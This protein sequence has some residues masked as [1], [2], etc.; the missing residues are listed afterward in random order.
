[1]MDP[2]SLAGIFMLWQS[3]T[4]QTDSLKSPDFVLPEIK[5][6][7]TGE[8]IG[9]EETMPRPSGTRPAA[10]SQ[11]AK[12]QTILEDPEHAR[13]ANSGQ[14]V[15]Q[16]RGRVVC[17]LGNYRMVQ[18]AFAG[19]GDA[20][21]LQSLYAL[22]VFYRLGP[23]D[24]NMLN[25]YERLDVKTGGIW[26]YRP[27]RHQQV[28]I[29]LG[30]S[31]HA[32][33]QAGASSND[34]LDSGGVYID[35]RSLRT[36]RNETME[37]HGRMSA[38][39]LGP[40]GG[41]GEI[42]VASPQFSIKYTPAEQDD[43]IP[44]SVLASVLSQRFSGI[45]PAVFTQIGVSSKLSSQEDSAS[46]KWMLGI[47]SG[48][49]QG[50]RMVMRLNADSAGGSMVRNRL[51]AERVFVP[52][53]FEKI[54]G[55]NPYCIVN[56][57]GLKAQTETR[58]RIS[59]HRRLDKDTIVTAAGGLS[60]IDDAVL[61]EYG[62]MSPALWKPEN[63]AIMIRLG[64]LDFAI[65]KSGEFERGIELHADR[66]LDGLQLPGISNRR[67]YGYIKTKLG[68]RTVSVG[69]EAVAGAPLDKDSGIASPGWAAVHAGFT[70]PRSGGILN[71]VAVFSNRGR[72]T[73]YG[74][75]E[76]AVDLRMTWEKQW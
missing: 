32:L 11:D 75:E 18:A 12:P 4:T 28:D 31:A 74:Y 21:D 42:G 44:V 56:T 53:A 26:A 9:H 20:K 49:E 33:R 72:Q 17:G 5:V 57:A 63:S 2:V 8:K 14:I 23:D 55:A 67:A 48:T 3:V 29:D 68:N 59:Q 27:D 47:G 60:M 54:Y 61:W 52:P 71:A 66:N 46:V 39:V 36:D 15:K 35:L 13:D 43:E 58:I 38:N 64:N 34:R 62:G 76:P 50:S 10:H 6:Y 65:R 19:M 73:W 45:A 37:F 30:L 22:D 25:G 1:M 70:G 40:R 7:G 69:V 41:I 16:P 51:T 24:Q